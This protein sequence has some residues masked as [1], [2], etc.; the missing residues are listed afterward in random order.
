MTVMMVDGHSGGKHKE[1]SSQSSVDA[2]KKK[3]GM[4]GL[5]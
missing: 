2:I 1:K 4:I 3:L 5:P